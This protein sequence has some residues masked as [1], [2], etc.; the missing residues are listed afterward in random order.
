VRDAV[1]LLVLILGGVYILTRHYEAVNEQRLRAFEL[2]VQ[3]NLK[4][5]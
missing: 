4:C 1:F 3:N 2:C 5:G